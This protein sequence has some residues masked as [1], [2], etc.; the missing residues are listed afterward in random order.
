MQEALSQKES[1]AA[2]H[3]EAEVAGPI[4]IDAKVAQQ[5]GIE[6]RTAERGTVSILIPVTGH[7]VQNQNTTAEVKARFEGVVKS[8]NKTQGETVR[9]GDIL[10]TVE[11]N[12]SL[13]VYPVRAPV[14]GVIL[15]R[16]INI[17]H[18]T[19]VEPLFIIAD[20]SKLWVEVYVFPKDAP[21]V[22]AGQK[23]TLKAVA[24]TAQAKSSIIALLPLV[25]SESQTVI[26]RGEIDNVESLWR[27]G[28]SVLG[29]I[30]AETKEA[31]VTVDAAAPQRM[32][33]KTVIFVEKDGAFEPRP[34][35]LGMSDRN[36][37]EVLEGL[38]AGERY[39]AKGSFVLKADAEKSGAEHED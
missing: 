15:A 1:H 18:V 33:G 8:V 6:A 32:D 20:L 23:L 26:A 22:K 38:Q 10:A 3:A 31:A 19:G 24:A 29:N 9:A 7:I 12:S 34:V 37:S 17:G 30:L 36:L 28:M 21:A 27:P 14:G 25:E 16:N 13:E 11:S 39:V 35:T 2:G 4:R 5:M